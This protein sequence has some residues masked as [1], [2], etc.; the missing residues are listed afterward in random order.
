VSQERIY[1]VGMYQRA[2]GVGSTPFERLTTAFM[3][4]L[5]IGRQGLKAA[6]AGRVK[7]AAAK[8]ER[9]QAIVHRMDQSLDFSVAPELCTNLSR[10]YTHIQ[11]VLDDPTVGS[12]P[13]SFA[14]C[15]EILTTLWEG[16]QAAEE[17][18]KS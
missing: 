16:F 18:G 17:K 14:E 11:T 5:R 10:L 2:V 6:N 1:Q 13:E 8:G 15:I 7:D 9:L 12:K 4:A 3:G